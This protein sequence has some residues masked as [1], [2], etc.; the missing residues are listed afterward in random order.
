MAARETGEIPT[1]PAVAGVI[2]PA[3]MATGPMAPRARAA[4]HPIQVNLVTNSTKTPQLPREQQ[5]INPILGFGF[6][7]S[8]GRS[9]G[10]FL[11]DS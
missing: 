5:S 10:C 1:P 7:L 6:C 4:V 11:T 2:P 9:R 3:V 8:R